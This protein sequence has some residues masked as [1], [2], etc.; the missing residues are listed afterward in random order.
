V[1]LRGGDVRGDIG[2]ADRGA[3][4]VLCGYCWFLSVESDQVAQVVAG[5]A[6]HVLLGQA[7]VEQRATH[8]QVGP[9][10]EHDAPVLHFPRRS[11][12]ARTHPGAVAVRAR[13]ALLQLGA[14]ALAGG[15]CSTSRRRSC[16]AC[17][18]P[19]S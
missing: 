7:E 3:L 2:A 19:R 13:R 15:A 6:L 4:I 5:H 12:P 9:E 10:P 17:A 11:R 18:S 8:A 14:A 16:V 1:V